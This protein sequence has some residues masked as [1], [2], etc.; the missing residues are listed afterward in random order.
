MRSGCDADLEPE[1]VGLVVA[2]H[3]VLSPEDGDVELVRRHGEPLGRGHQLPGVG[4][5]LLLEI[6]AKAEVAEHL[7]EGVVAVGEAHVFQVVVLAAGAHALLRA[8]WRA[9]SRASRRPGRRP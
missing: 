4:N 1:V 7:E 8:W 2:R 3:A 9:C 6:V 5:G